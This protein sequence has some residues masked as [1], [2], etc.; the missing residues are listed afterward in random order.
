MTRRQTSL[1]EIF[2]T[3]IDTLALTL[4]PDTVR[5]YRCGV[6]SFL[7]YL[8]VAF[9]QLRQLSQLRRDPHLL[10]WFRWLAGHQPSL[11]NSTRTTYLVG[12]H[13][14]LDALA[15]NGQALPDLIRP[16]D[17]P[18]KPLSFAK[19]LADFR[20][21]RIRRGFVTWSHG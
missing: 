19:S 17:F 12:V 2:E 20:I 4:R 18:P 11:S 16:G 7:S 15:A 6:R 9:P 10:G 14:L 8:R 21:N 5:T 1:A 3:Q 13:H